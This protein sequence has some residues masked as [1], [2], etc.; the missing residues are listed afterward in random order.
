MAIVT[1]TSKNM[2]VIPKKARE[3]FRLHEGQ[4]LQVIIGDEEMVVS[5]MLDIEQLAGALKGPRTSKELIQE[6]RKNVSRYD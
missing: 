4:K 3:H 6:S 1:I 5:P 2:I